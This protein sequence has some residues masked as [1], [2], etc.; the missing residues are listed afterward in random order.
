MSGGIPASTSSVWLFSIT[1]DHHQRCPT[2]EDISGHGNP[3]IGYGSRVVRPRARG[4]GGRGTRGPSR[5]CRT[6]QAGRRSHEAL[7]RASRTQRLRDRDRGPRGVQGL[8]QLAHPQVRL[9]GMHTIEL[10]RTR[11]AFAEF[12][13]SHFRTVRCPLIPHA[14]RPTPGHGQRLLEHAYAQPR[15]A[16]VRHA[17][18]C[19]D[20]RPGRV[21][22]VGPSPTRRP[23]EPDNG[24]GC[25]V[26]RVPSEPRSSTTLRPPP[27][28][29]TGSDPRRLR[30]LTSS[31]RPA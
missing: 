26:R 5:S 1:R 9:S 13:H 8:L 14:R 31:G 15:R 22:P 20:P 27:L 3:L 10:C 2:T 29:R 12:G 19:A 7:Y 16:V 18:R 30:A 17:S 4:S 21:L 24:H 25:P 6:A 11:T 23:S 28:P